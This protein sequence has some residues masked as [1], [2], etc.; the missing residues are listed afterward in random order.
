M[1]SA[2]QSVSNQSAD[3]SEQWG[4]SGFQ[5]FKAGVLDHLTD[6]DDRVELDLFDNGMLAYSM[7]TMLHV[8]VAMSS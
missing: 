2:R 3:S 6:A 5:S 1:A 8:C 7:H 4:H